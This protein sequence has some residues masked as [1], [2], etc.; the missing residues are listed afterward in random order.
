[1][2]AGI[3]ATC[4]CEILTSGPVTTTDATREDGKLSCRN[5][6]SIGVPSGTGIAAYHSQRRPSG[7]LRGRVAHGSDVFGILVSGFL[8]GHQHCEL[9]L[10][11]LQILDKIALL[12]IGKPKVET[13]VIAVD[14]IQ[15]GLEA[16]IVIEAPLILRKHK[17]TAFAHE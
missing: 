2:T 13:A 16:P 15:K 7:H 14:D 1:M 9:L 4:R 11:R 8:V 10:K 3:V 5:G 6:F 17:K 12:I